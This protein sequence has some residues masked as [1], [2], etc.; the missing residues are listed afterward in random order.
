MRCGAGKEEEALG[1]VFVRPLVLCLVPE[2][3][4]ESP[5]GIAVGIVLSNSSALSKVE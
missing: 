5:V 1:G 3:P 4:F 2:P